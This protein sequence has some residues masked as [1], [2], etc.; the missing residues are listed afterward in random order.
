MTNTNDSGP[1]SLRE[2]IECIADGGTIGFHPSLA[3]AIIHLTSDRIIIDKEV[4]I[5]ST[6][7][8]RVW[9]HSDIPGAFKINSGSTVQ[10]KNINFTSGLSGTPG[11]AFEN[12]GH[13]ILWDASVIRNPMLLPGNYLIYNG[14][15]GILTAKGVLQIE[16][17]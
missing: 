11:A 1:G 10:F 17:D 14:V 16:V 6:L 12:Y 9:V 2:I 7:S 8:P 4:Y 3:D 13:L 5:N 15:P